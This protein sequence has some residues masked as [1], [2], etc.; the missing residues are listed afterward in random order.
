MVKNTEGPDKTLTKQMSGTKKPHPN[1]MQFDPKE[2]GA[3]GRSRGR[4]PG[5]SIVVNLLFL[6]DESPKPTIFDSQNVHREI[7]HFVNTPK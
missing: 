2:Q 6:I 3:S 5:I 1:Q 4:Q 7:F